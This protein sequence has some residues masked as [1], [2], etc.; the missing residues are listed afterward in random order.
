MWFKQT[1]LYQL[2]PCPE[3]PEML[4]EK[5]APFSF[6][7]CLPSMPMTQ[8]WVPP[9]QE[10]GAPLVHSI[11]G[12]LMICMQFEEKLLP[13]TVIRQALSQKIKEIETLQNRRVGQKEKYALKDEIVRTL[14]PRAFTQLTPVHAY[15]DS[16]HHYLV[17]DSTHE[18]KLETVSAFLKRAVGAETKPPGI[19]NLMPIMTHWLSHNSHPASISIEKDCV[20][21]DPNQQKS[22]IRCQQQDLFSRSIQSL[23]KDGYQVKQLALSWREQV[24]FVLHDEGSLRQIRF[25][26][27]VIKTAKT[28]YADTEAQIFDADFFVMTALLSELLITLLKIFTQDEMKIDNKQQPA[29]MMT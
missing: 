4:A 9:L 7:P 29:T 22:L 18:K 25:Q 26:D 15:I 10:E 1:T 2:S 11:P 13:A 27:D 23:L 17:V 3:V 20:F 19:K 14:L 24:N 28:H 8:G 12:F 5:L 6:T 21:Q 16:Q